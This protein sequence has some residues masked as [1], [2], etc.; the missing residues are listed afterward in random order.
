M[1]EWHHWHNGH[2][3]E[4]TPGI[5][6]DREAWCAAVLGITKRHDLVTQQPPPRVTQNSPK[7][8][9]KL[10]TSWAY[11]GLA[12]TST[13]QVCSTSAQTRDSGPSLAPIHK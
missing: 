4:Q 10:K 12:A 5:V 8:S 11:L 13:P 1:V 3:F 2:E 6:K 9:L 7:N